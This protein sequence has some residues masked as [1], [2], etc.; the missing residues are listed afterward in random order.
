MKTGK[1]TAEFDMELN[2]D[3]CGPYDNAEL[4][5]T[6]SI[7]FKQINPA[8][9]ADE[10]TYHSY[11]D[12]TEPNKKIIKWTPGTWES[13][14]T[15]FITSAQKYWSGRFW[16]I[17]N[18]PSYT[19]DPF[20]LTYAVN[21]QIYV[22]N[23]YCRLNLIG[24]DSDKGA[25]NFVVEVVRLHPSERFFGSHSRLY[26]TRDTLPT[27]KARDTAGKPIMQRAHVHEVGH[28]LGLGHVDEGKANCPVSGDTNART[29]YGVSDV[30][31]RSV[32]G[33]GM[34]LR[35]ENAIPWRKSL[36][37]LTGLGAART[38]TDWT[39]K[40]VRH[41]PRTLAEVEA[42]RLVTT[43]LKR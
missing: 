33:N 11:G 22:A 19:H 9:G 41:Y 28:L 42:K 13:W 20:G 36:V 15:E 39:A 25:N 32:M 38:P 4:T 2:T 14:K 30:D 40:L 21:G 6:L 24:N 31:K 16:L 35:V 26:D 12:A 27:E 17:N 43:K 5:I 7:G 3:T 1:S 29:C 37:E 8:G 34:E 10:G 18:F 23:V